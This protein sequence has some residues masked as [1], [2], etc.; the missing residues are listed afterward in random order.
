MDVTLTGDHVVGDTDRGSRK[1]KR[2]LTSKERKSK[3]RL[4]VSN[5]RFSLYYANV[6]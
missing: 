5:F 3:V 2:N 6:T 4:V 1:R